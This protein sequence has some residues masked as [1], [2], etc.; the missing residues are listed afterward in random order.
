MTITPNEL[1]TTASPNHGVEGL[2]TSNPQPQ[3]TRFGSWELV[4][5]S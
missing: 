3:A 2:T 4:V 5:G 1:P